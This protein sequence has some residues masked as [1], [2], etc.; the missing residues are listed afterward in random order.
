MYAVIKPHDLIQTF[1]INLI[2]GSI[3]EFKNRCFHLWNV[4]FNEIFSILSS[5]FKTLMY[6]CILICFFVFWERYFYNMYPVK[7]VGIS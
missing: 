7:P 2:L 1:R 6:M 3:K 5:L 4:L